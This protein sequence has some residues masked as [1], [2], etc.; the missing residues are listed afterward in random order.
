M[1]KNLLKHNQRVDPQK[2]LYVIYLRI[3]YLPK[4]LFFKHF[5]TKNYD[6]IIFKFIGLLKIF[7]ITRIDEQCRNEGLNPGKYCIAKPYVRGS[8]MHEILL[9][10]WEHDLDKLAHS[11]MLGLLVLMICII[12]MLESAVLFLPLPGDSLV[13]MTGALVGLG[14]IGMEV[15]F[16]YLPI[17]AG[18]GSILAYWQGYWLRTSPVM[19]H[20]NRVVPLSKL[21]KAAELVS[22]YG[23]SSMFLS[24]FIPF[25]R[26]ITP[27][28][29]G[30]NSNKVL[31]FYFVSVISA[32]MWV[33]S[34]GF[35]GEL[36]MKIEVI[37]HYREA[38]TKVIIF[39]TI[40]AFV[41]AVLA[42]L[43]RLC[44]TSQ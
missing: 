28:L 41:T 15:I 11:D 3:D 25:V 6:K 14:V 38:I 16:I 33:L 31:R 10:I 12:L 1:Y 7:S 39:G 23:I 32:F 5:S 24:R 19:R 17:A 21:E 18:L 29:I 13:F 30:N 44:K 22:K 26:V 9:A 8:T 43:F 4:H 2:N 35:I 42:V 20:L 27:M 40:T 37:A 36:S 34:I